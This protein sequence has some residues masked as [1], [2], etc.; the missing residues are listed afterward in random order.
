MKRKRGNKVR[1]PIQVYLTAAER[2][3]LDRLAAELGISR[4]EAL[5]RGLDALATKR[6]QS[7]YDAFDAYLRTIP[8]FDSPPDLAE[9]H[10]EYLARD[11]EER[12]TRYR[13]P[14]S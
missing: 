12:M 3:K 9:K 2:A 14:S 8:D 1:E 10:D 13:R 6:S 11:M 4:A 5:R 7:F